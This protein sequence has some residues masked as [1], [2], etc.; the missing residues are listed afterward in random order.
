MNII[1]KYVKFF[2][3]PISIGGSLFSDSL[4]RKIVFSVPELEEKIKEKGLVYD[5]DTSLTTLCYLVAMTTQIT[6]LPSGNSQLDEYF[7]L[8]HRIITSKNPA[9]Q[10]Q[11]WLALPEAIKRVWQDSFNAAQN[12]F[13]L[14][15]ES[16]PE[17]MLSTK[18]KAGLADK[19]SPLA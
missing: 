12:L 4:Y 9:E 5:T 13:D 1:Q 10:W 3:N 7:S 14:D 17:E 11:L 2:V 6:V 19:Q 18:D 15:S 8:P 16:A